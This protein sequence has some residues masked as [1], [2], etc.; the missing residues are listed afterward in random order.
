MKGYKVIRIFIALLSIAAP[1]MAQENSTSLS[2]YYGF[3]D[4]DIKKLRDNMRCLRTAD[5]NKDGRNDIAA[6]NNKDSKIEILLQKEKVSLA[7]VNE[8]NSDANDIDIN[9]INS[10][11]RFEKAPVP[12]SIKI[13]NMVCGDLN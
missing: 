2:A 3:G 10:E 4:L 11:T 9:E 1:V 5:F 13:A 12:V 7:A 8:P 6:V